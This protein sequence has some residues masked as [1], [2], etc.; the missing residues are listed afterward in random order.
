MTVNSQSYVFDPRPHYPLLIPAKRYW[1]PESLFLD[2]PNALTLIFAHGTGFHKEHWEPTIDDLY[3][4]LGNNRG[5]K[6]RE[7][8]AIECPN[9]GDGAILNEETLQWGY[10]PCKIQRL[11]IA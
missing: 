8:W 7:M 10:D 9:H 5:I 4:I 6:V 11:T 1:I 2:D 3:E